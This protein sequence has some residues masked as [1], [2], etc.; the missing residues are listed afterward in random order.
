MTKLI[1][2]ASL[3]T[4]STLHADPLVGRIG[5]IELHASE[6]RSLIEA[7]GPAETPEPAAVDQF[8][9]ALL[10]QRLVLVRA[11]EAGHDKEPAVLAKLA[12]ARDAALAESYLA[13]VSEPPAGFP[14]RSDLEAAYERDKES[15]RVPKSYHLAQIFIA[16]APDNQ[17][18]ADTR[19]KEV[20]SMLAKP[21]A[22]FAA[23]ARVHSDDR[24]SAPAGG[25]LGWLQEP[26]IQPAI[27]E[28]L[29][30]LD[31]GAI[32]KPVRLDDG[33][34]LIRLIDAREANTP[35]LDQIRPQLSARLRALKARD[36]RE[37]FLEKLLGENP[38]A[39]N[40]IELRKV[41]PDR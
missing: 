15:F 26:I 32:S 7:L 28:A 40:E 8:V 4:V 21:D 34:H 35:T 39:V 41:A 30:D 9:R 20:Q 16:A 11:R 18:A 3:I 12:R 1:T 5:E 19:L 14:T 10:V 29:P 25:D 27:R 38:L 22:D 2:L 6:V 13:G 17:A 33:W 23:L 31:L 36:L 37:E 24:A